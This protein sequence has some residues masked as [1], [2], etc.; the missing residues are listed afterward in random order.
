[1][2]KHTNYS[3]SIISAGLHV[4][5]CRIRRERE[6]G[7][8]EVDSGYVNETCLA[9]STGGV[10]TWK[11]IKKSSPRLESE[12]LSTATFYSMNP[13]PIAPAAPI[14]VHSLEEDGDYP[15]QHEV[16]DR[17]NIDICTTKHKSGTGVTADRVRPRIV[18]APDPIC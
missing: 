11:N 14:L 7:R 4:S 18:S 17:I 12:T 9:C 6:H 15:Q 16:N 13:E 5:R 10:P 8:S 2:P 3:T 1:M